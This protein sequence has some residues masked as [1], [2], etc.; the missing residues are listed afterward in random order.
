[1]IKNLSHEDRMRLMRF[2]C[3]F[4]WADLA[5]Q[6]KEREF[7]H[8]LVRKFELDESE[9]KQVDAWLRVPP[10]PEEVDPTQVPHQH[11]KLFLDTV[12]EMILADGR[13]QEEEIENWE[14]LQQLLE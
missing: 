7:V 4:A 2:V 3:S 1:M 10:K 12:K 9:A 8:S 14:L 11:R 13:A 5:I 6:P